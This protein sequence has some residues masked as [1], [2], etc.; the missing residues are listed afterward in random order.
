[1]LPTLPPLSA[2]W[3]QQLE[4]TDSILIIKTRYFLRGKALTTPQAHTRLLAD[5]TQ[6]D[7]KKV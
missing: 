2:L 1:L 5:R 6:N 3:E 7:I 4:E